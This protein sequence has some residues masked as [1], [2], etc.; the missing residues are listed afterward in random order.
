MWVTGSL[1]PSAP[2]WSEG[3]RRGPGTVLPCPRSPSSA[4]WVQPD[5]VE[6]P[7]TCR[8]ERA[9]PREAAR[10]ALG[11]TRLAVC[12]PRERASP[13]AIGVP[14]PS[15][16]RHPQHHLPPSLHH[17]PA[18]SVLPRGRGSGP[19]RGGA[20]ADRRQAGPVSGPAGHMT[21]PHSAGRTGPRRLAVRP[22]CPRGESLHKVLSLHREAGLLTGCPQS[23]VIPCRL[24]KWPL[25]REAGM[26]DACGTHVT[27][28]AAPRECG[29]PGVG[30]GPARP[31]SL[32]LWGWSQGGSLTEEG[33]RREAGG[34]AGPGLGL[35]LSAATRGGRPPPGS[36]IHSAPARARLGTKPGPRGQG[37]AVDTA[38]GPRGSAPR[39]IWLQATLGPHPCPRSC[40]CC[41]F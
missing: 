7:A 24:P 30:E 33:G 6:A 10:P 34:G 18:T 20:Q 32:Q 9:T 38:E 27:G 40:G 4:R 36:L 11:E 15:T 5:G 3:L 37:P 25:G 13:T 19:P 26:G 16:E 8:G 22:L 31:V 41:S 1:C 14:D 17:H 28:R 35:T 39:P 12:P 2:S 23:S 29:A 21:G